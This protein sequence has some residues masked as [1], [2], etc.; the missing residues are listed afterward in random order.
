[1]PVDLN[2]PGRLHAE[3]MAGTAID[4]H[5]PADRVDGLLGKRRRLRLGEALDAPRFLLAHPVPLEALSPM[6]RC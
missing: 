2:R 6:V 5:G 4:H 1:M 3:R